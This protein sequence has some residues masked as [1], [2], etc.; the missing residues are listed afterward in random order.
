MQG[1]YKVLWDIQQGVDI[2]D[3]GHIFEVNVE[4]LK[5]IPLLKNLSK[6]LL[7]KIGMETD[8]HHAKQDETI[9]QEGTKGQYFSIIASCKVSILKKFDDKEK[10][11]ATLEI[12]DFFWRNL[13]NKINGNYSDH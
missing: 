1:K 7:E 8:I 11:L 5:H 9:I 4:T 12:G 3:D 2:G 13:I 10:Q 6:K